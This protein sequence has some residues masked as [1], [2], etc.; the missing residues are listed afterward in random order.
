MELLSLRGR[1]DVGLDLAFQTDYPVR[2]TS[3]SVPSQRRHRVSLQYCAVAELG[4]HGVDE[5]YHRERICSTPGLQCV[6][7]NTLA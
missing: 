4:V 1:T 2:T 7:P 5:L 3:L 6:L